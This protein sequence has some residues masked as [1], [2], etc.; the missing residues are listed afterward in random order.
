MK[1][2]TSVILPL[3]LAGSLALGGQDPKQTAPKSTSQ[4]KA[5]PLATTHPS[6]TPPAITTIPAS[7]APPAADMKAPATK[8]SKEQAGT[9]ALGTMKGA[10]VASS[11]LKE[12]GGKQVWAVT[13]KEGEKKHEVMVD[14]TE[15]TIV[16]HD[17]K[18][19][20]HHANGAE[21]AKH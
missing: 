1:T 15:G 8:I 11:E 3:I 10:A 5:A 6:G 13:L 20:K 17:A 18:H 19:T 4:H 7:D 14:A 9:I 16:K 12:V 21:P 2:A